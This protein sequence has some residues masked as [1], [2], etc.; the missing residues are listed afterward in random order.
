MLEIL[1]PGEKVRKIRK[2]IG[3]TQKEVAGEGVTRNLISQ[4][5][6]GK[7]KLSMT[8][9]KIICDNIKLIINKKNIENS[10]IKPTT[11]WLLEDAYTQAN[12]IADDYIKE[13]R[14]IE[15]EKKKDDN[16]QERV[17]EIESF[18][19][20]WDISLEK[21]SQIYELIS[22]I[23][24]S[25]DNLNES[26]LKMQISL[27]LSIQNKEYDESI[28]LMMA[29]CKRMDSSGGNALE[30]LRTVHLALNM[31]RENNLNNKNLLKKIYFNAAL[32]YSMIEMFDVS[33]EYLNQLI[34][35]CSLS[36]RETLD[37]NLL[38]GICY[39]DSN[40]LDEAERLYLDTLDISLKEYEA[41]VTSKIYCSLGTLYRLKGDRTNSLE[42]INYSLK[43]Q[44]DIEEKDY[45]KTL[46]YA[47]EN[48]IEMNDKNLVLKNFCLALTWLDK[49]RNG[50]MYY[51]LIL[52][53]YNY[54]INHND[55]S[56]IYKLL[57]KLEV[58]IKCKIVGNKE[59]INLFF[60][61]THIM[62]PIDKV[63]S[64]EL[65]NIGINL[66]DLP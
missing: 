49:T 60:K 55:Y 57:K 44:K 54:F 19:S 16:V 17:Q 45:G 31:Y 32:Y 50:T 62:K 34:E 23:Y 53:L 21:K 27:D 12:N 52:K 15:L 10:N 61:T 47:V 1:T 22:D 65:F 14:I 29:L 41:T 20:K 66:L 46:Y 5:E 4:I 63:K 39:E 56:N 25:L 40:R 9:A 24:F 51:E 2:M 26:F 37:V 3:A 58:A 36:T 11:E 64:Y 8:T 30:R 59:S 38:K 43:I 48:Y 28:R 7:T 18:I 13:L 6:N 35:E 42:Y 33:I